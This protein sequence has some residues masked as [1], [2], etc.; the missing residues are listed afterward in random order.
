MTELIEI[1]AAGFGSFFFSMLFHL[2]DI[3]LLAAGLGG[4]CT[5]SIC[6]AVT[7]A[8][9]SDYLAF[10]LSAAVASTAAE[11]LARGFKTPTTTFVVPLLIPLIPGGSLYY[12][13]SAAVQQ[14]WA[15]FAEK[16]QQTLFLSISLAAGIMAVSSLKKL[17]QGLWSLQRENHE[18]IRSRLE[19]RP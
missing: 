12:A 11:L 7:S 4:V 13:M 6:V 1:A 3:K 5:W 2:R 14:D 19:R 18:K 16:G 15:L 9:G 10:F 8:S 17:L